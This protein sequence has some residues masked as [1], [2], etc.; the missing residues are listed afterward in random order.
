MGS[1]WPRGDS[2][3]G[4]VSASRLF[5]FWGSDTSRRLFQFWAYNGSD[6]PRRL[7]G[8]AGLF[9]F[10]SGTAFV[11]MMSTFVGMTMT[12]VFWFFRLFR[13]VTFL[14]F[15]RTSFAAVFFFRWLS[16]QIWLVIFTSFRIWF[17]FQLVKILK[18]FAGSGNRHFTNWLILYFRIGIRRFG[19]WRVRRFDS[20]KKKL[21]TN[22]QS[23]V[24]IYANPCI[25]VQTGSGRMCSW[26]K[27]SV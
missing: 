9:V 26:V 10:R 27:N 25:P 17:L 20:E 18:G 15:G 22:L 5:L 13:F 6:T 23:L 12:L 7:F 3:W 1:T 24:K 8:V 19:I 4:T 16:F 21:K 11:T 2:R 14:S